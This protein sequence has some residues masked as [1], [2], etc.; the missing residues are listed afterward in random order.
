MFFFPFRERPTMGDHQTAL[1]RPSLPTKTLPTKEASP[2]L[3]LCLPFS[4]T[5]MVGNDPFCFLAESRE[6]CQLLRETDLSYNTQKVILQKK[7]AK[8]Y[9]VIL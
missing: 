7:E 5:N 9:N 2:H 6:V 3:V 4:L 1:E 8:I